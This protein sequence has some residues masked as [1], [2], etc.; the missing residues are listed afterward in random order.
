MTNARLNI[1]NLHMFWDARTQI[2]SRLGLAD[3]RNVVF[4]AFNRHQADGFNCARIDQ[5]F[6]AITEG[7]ARQSMLAEDTADRL[8]IIFLGEILNGKILIVKGAVLLSAIFITFDK[9]IKEP[10][11]R[12]DMAI[13]VHVHETG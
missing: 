11:L 1:V 9:M 8:Q 12:I 4:L 5:T 7:S 6:A 2:M 13:P 3:S 10:R